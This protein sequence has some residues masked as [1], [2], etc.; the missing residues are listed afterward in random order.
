MKQGPHGGAGGLSRLQSSGN[1][2]MLR[3]SHHPMSGP[4][5]P[6]VTDHIFQ[7]RTVSPT[8]FLWAPPPSLAALGVGAGKA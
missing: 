4:C 8:L 7:G 3:P 1:R 6:A 2:V 5:A